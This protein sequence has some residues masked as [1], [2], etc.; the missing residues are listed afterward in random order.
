MVTGPLANNASY[1]V[2]R[3]GPNNNP[4]TTVLDGIKSKLGNSINVTFEKGCDVT[5]AGWP[6]TEVIPTPLTH[7]EKDSIDRAVSATKN[8]DVIVA[9]LGEDESTVGES[10]SR[11]SLDFPGRQ[12][13][14]LEA[15][16]AT[17]KPVVLVVITGQPLTI[18]WADRFVPA[19]INTA[20][21]GPQGG[22]AIADV[23]FGDYNPGGRLS[24]T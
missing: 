2:S 17:D 6:E 10:L 18:N 9:I 20:F 19:I 15:L 7:N 23:L 22:K 5:N 12:Q 14:L 16:Y 1:A 8:A 24:N 21:P 3:Y 4:L 13:Q 11:T